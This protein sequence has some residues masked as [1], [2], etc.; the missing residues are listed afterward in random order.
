MQKKTIIGIYMSIL[1]IIYC[2]MLLAGCGS[3]TAA[4]KNQDGRYSVVDSQ[5]TTVEFSS[6]PKRILTLSMSTDEIILGLVKP[7]KLVAVN[8]LLDDSTSSNISGLVK[9][10]NIKIKNPSVEKIYSLKP[11]IVIV[12]NWGD[13]AKVNN[14]RDMGLNVVVVPGAKNIQ[15]VKISIQI[16]ADALG[17]HNKGIKLIALMDKK[18]ADIKNKVD[19]I[20][21]DKRKKLVLISLMS[22][23]GGIGSAFDD[24]CRSAGVIN[25]AATAGIH[26]GEA[27]TKEELVKI[28]P[29]I[30][31]MPTYNDHGTFNIE[32]YN[33]KYLLDPSLQTIKA[34]KDKKL[35]YPREGYIYNVSQDIVFGIQE[36]A[37]CVYGSEFNFP[38]NMHLSVVD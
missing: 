26:N 22:A 7:E 15:D 34:I 31:L 24:E 8:Y 36:I 27:L 2:A 25:G 11:D 19:K 38:D 30:L 14:L 16:I 37:R 1:L 10:I 35:I 9:N 32:K 6:R 17:E 21:E 18:L 20:P 28:N 13:L 12:P 33:Q 29:D 23:Y 4:I 5:G 3:N